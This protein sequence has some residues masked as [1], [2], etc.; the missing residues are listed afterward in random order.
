[1]NLFY[2]REWTT[3]IISLD[4]LAGSLMFW[5]KDQ[6]GGL[7]VE[8]E[9][10]LHLVWSGSELEEQSLPLWEIHTVDDL[11][12]QIALILWAKAERVLFELSIAAAS[13]SGRG[14]A[15]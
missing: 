2:E 8:H 10:C 4:D 3:E 5:S 9:G 13:T 14:K 1:M 12:S 11:E 15:L 7:Q 6:Y